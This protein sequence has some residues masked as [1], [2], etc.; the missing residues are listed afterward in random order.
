MKRFF[1]ATVL[2]VTAVA[3]AGGQASA[4]P[5]RC[6]CYNKCCTFCVKPYNAFSPVCC[7]T[8]F[9]DGCCP[10]F[11]CR[12][13]QYPQGL[14]PGGE[15][16][17]PDGACADGSCGGGAPWS[18]PAY[19]PSASGPVDHSPVMTGPA[20]GGQLPIPSTTPFQAPSPL[21]L[22]NGTGTQSYYSLL[23]G[24]PVQPVAYP[25]NYQPAYPAVPPMGYLPPNFPNPW[26][27]Q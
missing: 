14:A 27:Q 17:Y 8:L 1:L 25:Y 19:L 4:F 2:S 11:G 24:A 21:P 5:L 18:G 26:Y 12:T 16:G 9:C 3:L 22:P 15:A 23:Y 13:Q 6:K 10:Q 7:G 20:T